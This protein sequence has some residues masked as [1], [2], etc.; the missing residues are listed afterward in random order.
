MVEGNLIQF[1]EMGS[2]VGEDHYRAQQ[3]WDLQQEINE[4]ESERKT[5]RDTE[6]LTPPA[7]P[8]MTGCIPRTDKSKHKHK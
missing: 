6:K 2:V 1:S 8:T 5:E 3:L 7:N 4:R